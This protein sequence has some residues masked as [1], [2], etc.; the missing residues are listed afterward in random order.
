MQ[1]LEL[2]G[3]R[4]FALLMFIAVKMKSLGEIRKPFF[5]GCL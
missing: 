3:K 2:V 5:R 1:L 4:R